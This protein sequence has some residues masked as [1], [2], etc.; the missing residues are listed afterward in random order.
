MEKLK[1]DG[2]LRSTRFKI[3]KASNRDGR[4]CGVP[5]AVLTGH[6]VS[7]SPPCSSQLR[8]AVFMLNPR[9]VT[10]QHNV[11]VASNKVLS[12]VSIFKAKAIVLYFT[13]EL[14]T[15]NEIAGFLDQGFR[16]ADVDKV[17]YNGLELWELTRRR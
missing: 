3:A 16:R 7:A 13:G 9:E 8:P 15:L 4:R 17:F 6:F 14:P 10:G 5:T 1:G 2:G 11:T 12:Q